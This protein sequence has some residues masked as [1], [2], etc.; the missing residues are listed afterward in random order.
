MQLRGS[1]LGSAD[2]GVI[3]EPMKP[4]LSTEA[5]QQQNIPG[6]AEI[7]NGFLRFGC[8]ARGTGCDAART[9]L[10]GGAGGRGGCV[11]PAGELTG[12][13]CDRCQVTNVS[14]CDS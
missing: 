12:H 13:W 4:A 7:F 1:S 5:S 2:R 3:E 11:L 8:D 9:S 10:G 6:C 14:S